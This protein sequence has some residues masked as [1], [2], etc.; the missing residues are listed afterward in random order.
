MCSRLAVRA[1]D[2]Q[3]MNFRVTRFRPELTRL[4]LQ[5]P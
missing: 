1:E 4:P 2:F 5:V 3:L